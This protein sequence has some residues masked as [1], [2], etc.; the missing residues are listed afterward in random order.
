MP[1]VNSFNDFS[2]WADS[3]E[4]ISLLNRTVCL[5]VVILHRNYTQ[6]YNK[7]NYVIHEK[8]CKSTDL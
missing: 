6:W 1:L 2:P 7:N 8:Q 5:F 3:T 4:A